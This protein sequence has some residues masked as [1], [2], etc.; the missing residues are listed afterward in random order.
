MSKRKLNINV[1]YLTRV[2][3]HWNIVVNVRE[4]KLEKC[5]LQIVE[6]P[7]FFEGMIRGR[8]IFEAQH[9]TSRICGICSCGHTL[10]SIQAAEEAIGFIPTKQTLELRKFLL[11]MENLDSHILHI[12]FLAAP[13]LLGVKSFVPL[14]DSHNQVVRLALRMKKACNDV[15]DILVGRHIHPI[16]AIVGGFTKLPH[17]KDLD[18]MLNILYGMQSDMDATVELVAG[19]KFPEFERDTEYVALV[20]GDGEYPMLIG[21]IGSSD[22]KRLDKNEYKKVT[23]E[24]VVPHSSAKHAKWNRDSY[25]VGAL[26]RFNLNFQKLHPKAREVASA[27]KMKPK[28]IN[29]YLNTAAQLI[30]CVHFL[31]DGMRILEDFKK[32]GINY[33]EEI[34]VGLNEQ[35]RIKVQSGTGVGAVEVPRGTLFHSY[36]VDEKGIIIKANCIIPT[37]QNVNN[38]EW[39]MKKLVPEILNKSDQ[40]ITLALEMLVRAYDP[41]ISCS[42]H[43]LKVKY[44]NR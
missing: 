20:S 36:Q 15:C 30:E 1:E 26:A 5:E 29:P 37:S 35:N 23:N 22:G 2:E 34:I 38:I 10:A 24:F 17:E 16:S 7:R 42:A 40:D 21:D 44:V 27:L 6:A 13:D 8:S 4:G 9:I 19:L 12:Y 39:D 11:Y 31:E 32:T 33:E 25:A 18:A 14:I 3:G 28:V 43:F 41:C